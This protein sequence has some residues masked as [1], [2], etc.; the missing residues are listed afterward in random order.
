M[1]KITALLSLILIGGATWAQGISCDSCGTECASACGTR[2]F[3]SCCFNYLRRKRPDST[4]SV[5]HYGNIYY[6]QREHIPPFFMDDSPEKNS[7]SFENDKNFGILDY[8]IGDSVGWFLVLLLWTGM[9]PL[10]Y[11]QPRILNLPWAEDL[12]LQEAFYDN[13]E[14]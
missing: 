1:L 14:V 12:E 9:H 4:K 6:P 3:R 13:N 10:Q 7:R 11:Q 8:N 2:N 5:F